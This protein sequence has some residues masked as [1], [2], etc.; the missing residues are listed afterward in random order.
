MGIGLF[1]RSHS[2][3]DRCCGTKEIIREVIVDRAGKNPN[4][5]P[6]NWILEHS[7]QNGDFLLVHIRYPDCTNYEGRKMMLYRGCTIDDLKAQK[8]IDP[9]FSSNKKYHSPIARFEPTNEGW[10]IGIMT[11]K[12]LK[13]QEL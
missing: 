13:E 8:T 9:H 4:P 3:Y 12:M 2:S 10:H 6:Y 5:D 7:L 1:A 11:M